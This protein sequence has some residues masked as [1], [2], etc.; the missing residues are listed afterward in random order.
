M[1]SLDVKEVAFYLLTQGNW[2]DAYRQDASEMKLPSDFKGLRI[3][4]IRCGLHKLLTEMQMILPHAK[5]AACGEYPDDFCV[6]FADP[7]DID[8]LR[9]L[10][11]AQTLRKVS[12][13]NE[14]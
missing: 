12:R 14:R 8:E 1:Q 9:N 5:L 7:K 11:H 2:T 3:S 10:V 13:Q 6:L 4:G